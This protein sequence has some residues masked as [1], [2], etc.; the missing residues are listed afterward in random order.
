MLL[1]CLGSDQ[2][3]NSFVYNQLDPTS[4]MKSYGHEGDENLTTGRSRRI[5]GLGIHHF[6]AKVYHSPL[7]LCLGGA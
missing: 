2:Q 7:D 4:I 1:G 6:L 5:L 3:G